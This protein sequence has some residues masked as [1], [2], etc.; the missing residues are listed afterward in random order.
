[1]KA[2]PNMLSIWN[3]WNKQSCRCCCFCYYSVF[4]SQFFSSFL[5]QSSLLS[6]LQYVFNFVVLFFPLLLLLLFLW[7]LI[8]L[9]VRSAW[10]WLSI[11]NVLVAWNIQSNW[12]THEQVQYHREKKE[13]IV[14]F[15]LAIQIRS[16]FILIWLLF[17]S[18]SLAWCSR[19][20]KQNCEFIWVCVHKNETPSVLLMFF[21]ILSQKVEKINSF[22]ASFT[23]YGRIKIA[24][25]KMKTNRMNRRNHRR[26]N[27]HAEILLIPLVWVFLFFS[28]IHFAYFLENIYCFVFNSA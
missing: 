26:I 5:V 25:Y 15:W 27:T 23:L 12:F 9:L 20:S 11:N 13:F 16:K 2:I 8:L 18:L 28:F 24:P 10:W 6:L 1:M 7:I 22:V 4:F 3:E 17:F 19:I 14:C 21:F